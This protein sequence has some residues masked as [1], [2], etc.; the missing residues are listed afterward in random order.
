MRNAQ[1][2]HAGRFFCENGKFA[3]ARRGGREPGQQMARMTERKEEE[4]DEQMEELHQDGG[5]A[6]PQPARL[7]KELC[8]PGP[9]GPH[10]MARPRY[11][12]QSQPPARGSLWKRCGSESWGM[13]S[14]H[15]LAGPSGQP[16]FTSPPGLYTH[17]VIYLPPQF[18]RAVTSSLIYLREN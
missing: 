13:P 4:T 1:W 14:S 6:K 9:E 15:F 12:H 7:C 16:I 10:P 5:P 8:S 2:F 3:A 11:P 18:L 17:Y